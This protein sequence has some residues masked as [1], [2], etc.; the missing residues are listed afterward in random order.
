M[1]D[2][3]ASI[4]A[5]AAQYFAGSSS[6]QTCSLCGR[7]EASH[8]CNCLSPPTLFCLDCCGHHNA[9]YPHIVHYAIPIAALSQ[10]PDEYVRKSEA[11]KNGAMALRR[12]LDKIDQCCLEFDRMMQG[13]I[14]YLTEYRSNLLQQMQ[15]DK[16]VLYTTIEAA[17]Q[18][19]N[20]CLEQ[21][22]EPENGLARALWNLPSEQLQVVNYSVTAPD[23]WS[24]CQSWVQYQNQLQAICE[25]FSPRDYFAAVFGNRVGLYDLRSQTS[26][27]YTL[28]V[29]FDSGVSY[30]P[31]DRNTLMCIGAP[32]DN[33]AVYEL[34]L[35]S[36]QVTPQ[37]P[38]NTPR[39]NAGIAKTAD[40][41]Y[42]FGGLSKNNVCLSSCEKYSLKD[43]Q[44][45]PLRVDMHAG[46]GYFTPCKVG[47]LIYLPNFTTS[48]HACFSHNQYASRTM[49]SFNP[50]TEVFTLLPVSIPD[51]LCFYSVAFMAN[52]ELCILTDKKYMLRWKMESE[53]EFRISNTDRGCW[54][55]QPPLVIGS[56][57]LIANT[58][59]K[60]VEKFSLETYRFL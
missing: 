35:F 32:Q 23:L 29:N 37:A 38:L 51:F 56:V 2:G 19:A 8:F 15:G 24:L 41:V 43:R 48:L 45:L 44:W 11:L 18:E 53:S 58:M 22:L 30:L 49:E 9:K 60:R 33:T 31:L 7:H 12:N 10:N 36:L 25:Y 50:A 1:D 52:G 28:S 55:N 13:C 39:A 34:D 5:M 27:Q 42:A 17:V 4:V 26:A 6:N 16:E 54:S 21:G 40:F 20:S 14:N 3:R 57:V 59:T 47:D 46:S